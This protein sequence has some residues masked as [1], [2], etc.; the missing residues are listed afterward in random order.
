VAV[1]LY[2]TDD[3]VAALEPWARAAGQTVEETAR[4]AIREY[5][6]GH[7]LADARE[8]RGTVPD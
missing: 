1:D 4:Q 5:L 7:G 6:E 8:D 3:E 2:L